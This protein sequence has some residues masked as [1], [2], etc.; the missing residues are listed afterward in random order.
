MTALARGLDALRICARYPNG[1][2][3]SAVARELSLPRAAVRRSLLTLSA[4][5]YVSQTGAIF[6][7]TPKVLDLAAGMM[8]LPLPK[9]A[10]PVLQQLSDTLQESAS[11]AIL[12]GLDILYVARSESRRI[13]SVDLGIGAR[14]PAW[15]TSMGRVLLAYLSESQR[16]EH[17]PIELVA[18]TPR[19]IT[20]RVLLS[21]L[22]DRIRDDG[23]CIQDQELE[24]GLRS[25][26][27]PIW[28][29]EGRVVAAL[30]VSTQLQE[31]PFPNS[32]NRWSLPPNAQLPRSVRDCGIPDP[33]RSAAEACAASAKNSS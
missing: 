31:H 30:N 26:A 32:R 15:C 18:R 28:G 20:D 27:V 4:M 16:R 21:T 3:L 22:L 29:A 10:H 11:V 19:T 12:D 14:L 5:G 9:L 1:M 25:V 17:M 6:Q 2:T 8:N 7:I 24:M 23:Y 33:G 13:L